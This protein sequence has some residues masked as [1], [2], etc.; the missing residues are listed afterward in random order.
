MRLRRPG[1]N[2]SE[3]KS[4]DPSAEGHPLVL[5]APPPRSREECEAPGGAAQSTGGSVAV[6]AF[7]GT[8]SVAASDNSTSGTQA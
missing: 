8:A 7:P 3:S 2:P 6:S 1:C 4:P 5:V